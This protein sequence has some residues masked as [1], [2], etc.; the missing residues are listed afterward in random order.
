MKKQIYFLPT[1][2]AAFIAMCFIGINAQAQTTAPPVHWQFTAP[3]KSA[4]TVADSKEDWI[5]NLIQASDGSLVAAGYVEDQTVQNTTKPTIFKYFNNRKEVMWERNGKPGIFCTAKL[6]SKAGNFQ[7]VIEANGSYYAVGWITTISCLPRTNDEILIGR[8]P[9]VTGSDQVNATPLSETELRATSEGSEVTSRAFSIR[10]IIMNNQVDGF[11]VCGT[12]TVNGTPKA[13]IIK[14]NPDLSKDQNFGNQGTFL[15]ENNT[16]GKQAIVHYNSSNAPDGFYMVGDINQPTGLQVFNLD[17]YVNAV[18]LSGSLIPSFRHIYDDTNIASVTGYTASGKTMTPC[19]DPILASPTE[20]GISIEQVHDAQGDGFILSTQFNAINDFTGGKC[21]VGDGYLDVDGMLIRID[22]AGTPNWVNRAARFTGIDYYTPVKVKNG[23]YYLLGSN[24]DP[25]NHTALTT[26]VN[27]KADGTSGWQQS[28]LADKGGAKLNC[29]FGL[30]IT[31]D[32]GFAIG[33]NNEL[34]DEDFY[35]LKL[36]SDCQNN[37]TF[38]GDDIVNGKDITSNEVWTTSR[39]VK[40]KIVVKAGQTLRIQNATISFL[41]SL[42]T[43]DYRALALND[44]TAIE[45]KIIVEPTGK[46]VLLNA[47]LRGINSC[48]KDWMWEGVEVRGNPNQNSNLQGKIEMTQSKIQDAILGLALD[49]KS[50]NANGNPDPNNYQ[51][52]GY[53]KVRNSSFT[54]CRKSVSFAP[55]NDQGKDNW[56]EF[57]ETKFETT[58][59]MVDENYIN[60]DAH[61]LGVNEHVSMLGVKGVSFTDCSWNADY[62]GGQGMYGVGMRTW[63]ASAYV[64]S[65]GDPKTK[66]VPN[67]RNLAWGIDAGFSVQNPLRSYTITNNLFTNVMDNIHIVSG[68]NTIIDG[69]VFKDIPNLEIGNRRSYGIDIM[70][71]T[72]NTISRNTFSSPQGTT[73]FANN[74]IFATNTSGSNATAESVIFGNDFT[75]LRTGMHIQKANSKM[76]IRCNNFTGN[77]LAAMAI[78]TESPEGPFND[79][80]VCDPQRNQAGNKFNDRVCTIPGK[81]ILTELDAAHTFIYNYRANQPLEVPDCVKGNVI[82]NEC[83]QFQTNPRTC[84]DVVKVVD[85]LCRR[86]FYS[87]IDGGVWLWTCYIPID[88]VFMGEADTTSRT[89]K[90]SSLIRYAQGMVDTNLLMTVLTSNNS[91]VYKK[92]SASAKLEMKKS[93]EARALHSQLLAQN[94]ISSD[95]YALYSILT[96]LTEQD[97]NIMQLDTTQIATIRAISNGN[98]DVKYTAKGILSFALGEGYADY[99]ENVTA[100]FSNNNSGNSFMKATARAQTMTLSPNPTRDVL[101]IQL[102]NTELSDDTQLIVTD[103]FG[104]TVKNL[105]LGSVSQYVLSVQDMTNGIYFC[106]LISNQKTIEIQKFSIIK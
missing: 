2:W 69:N 20:R 26:L 74:G 29:P 48:G 87:N 7:D 75:D 30:A 56:S 84:D 14:L 71:S 94:K 100:S 13:F 18:T 60:I 103:M 98:S 47:T 37:L 57:S 16:F 28:Y 58:N 10:P 12:A 65:P 41:S 96:D 82:P 73:T 24:I 51:G 72:L 86:V 43:N 27:V 79:Q 77:R 11:I 31:A 104:R 8:V 97:K 78:N 21:G 81:H 67:F 95:Y 15:F 36:R 6:S 83:A 5:Y 62:D 89:L 44:G 101:N 93:S 106:T 32:G 80:G 102:S 22:V 33:G 9:V 85:S 38:S 61:R 54:N 17:V 3:S 50:F 105:R 52:G 91:V 35:I 19:G 42:E 40:G 63:D 23:E 25:V 70:E 92:L 59:A 1:F 88:S 53:A 76:T 64:T 68:A 34:H 55:H 45:T 49:S 66:T 90:Q 39:K 4:P 46:L 99:F